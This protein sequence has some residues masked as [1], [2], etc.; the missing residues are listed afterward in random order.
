[1]GEKTDIKAVIV[2]PA[3][4]GVVL[5]T[6]AAEMVAD[7][8]FELGMEFGHY[9]REVDQAGAGI[10]CIA[11]DADEGPVD[12]TRQRIELALVD[13]IEQ[14]PELL[15]W[16]VRVTVVE[17]P[18]DD[19]EPPEGDD[20][21]AEAEPL[22]PSGDDLVASLMADI[23]YERSVYDDAK[24]FRAIPV[25][26]L[27]T[28]DLTTLDASQRDAALQRASALAG[29]LVQASVIAVDH[30]I[31]DI[32][33]LREQGKR[34]TTASIDETWVLSDLPSQFSDKYTALFAQ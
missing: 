14:T 2:A 13:L 34:G 3:A 15:G 32:A 27:S 6:G 23:H 26:D 11:I 12:A 22:L 24:L 1:M 20:L 4:S 8:I 7:A 17:L 19:A 28:E 31:S 21:A 16:N 30:L 25:E 5:L 33:E 18:L 29:C 10:T 9:M